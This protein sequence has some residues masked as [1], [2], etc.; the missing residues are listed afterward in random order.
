MKKILRNI[1]LLS[2]TVFLNSGL[3]AQNDSILPNQY[4]EYY[5]IDDYTGFHDTLFFNAQNPVSDTINVNIS[6]G[7][8]LAYIWLDGMQAYIKKGASNNQGWYSQITFPDTF[9]ILYDFDLQPGDTASCGSLV[10]QRDTLVIQGENRI[11]LNLSGGDIWVQ[12]IG[13][14]VFP[15]NPI[16]LCSFYLTHLCSGY[17]EYSGNSGIDSLTYECYNNYYGLND[18]NDLGDLGGFYCSCYVGINE[19][20]KKPIKVFPN[21]LHSGQV[22]IDNPRKEYINKVTLYHLTGEQAFNE[23]FDS[24]DDKIS[25]TI[26]G[27]SA[28]L[29]LL[30]IDTGENTLIRKIQYIND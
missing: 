28:G 26:H 10:I 11:V 19:I 2:L 30:K 24:Y 7:D 14:L 16:G 27:L 18:A 22:N 23:V 12:G 25:F 9:E 17:F 3:S 13:S 29:Y 1:A 4:A 20:E 21:P 5:L 8:T 15:F 6:N